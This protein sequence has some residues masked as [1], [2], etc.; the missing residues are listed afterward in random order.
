MMYRTVRLR[1]DYWEKLERMAAAYQARSGITP[2]SLLRNILDLA[3]YEHD[4]GKRFVTELQQTN[5]PKSLPSP[6][7]TRAPHSVVQTDIPKVKT[8]GDLWVRAKVEQCGEH[9]I[10][11]IA[12][13]HVREAVR[14]KGHLA[15]KDLNNYLPATE[16]GLWI[17]NERGGYRSRYGEHSV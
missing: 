11:D 15:T 8:F 17:M 7:E 16:K 12:P 3:E 1:Q 2:L 13:E 4:S 10:L 14:A 9:M 5:A 6:T